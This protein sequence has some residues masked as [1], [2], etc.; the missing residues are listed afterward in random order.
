MI[1]FRVSR[2]AFLPFLI[3]SFFAGIVF[4]AVYDVFRIR[5][6]AFAR[7]KTR[8]VIKRVD[9]VI[10]FLE[11]VIFSLFIAVTMIL[12][13]YK[14]YFGIPRW[15]SFGGAALGFFIYRITLGRLVIKLADK[16]IALVIAFFSF[17]KMKM[18]RPPIEALKR[19]SSGLYAKYDFKRLKRLTDKQEKRM[20][21][22]LSGK[23]K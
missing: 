5:R 11:D 2:E 19:V 17:I 7:D 4:G 15:Y 20:L 9:A 8:R 18:I 13:C 23:A 22:M 21:T 1:L 14:L 6:I 3:F 10:I 12:I 16:I